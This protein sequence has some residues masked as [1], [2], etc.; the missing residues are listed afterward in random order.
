MKPIKP[1][2]HNCFYKEIRE[3]GE[4]CYMF[5]DKPD[6]TPPL[7]MKWESSAEEANSEDA[8]EDAE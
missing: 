3:A 5:D 1:T 6:G 8:E 7:C 2:C 4:W